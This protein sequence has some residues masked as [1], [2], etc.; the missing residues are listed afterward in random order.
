MSDWPSSSSYLVQSFFVTWGVKRR[1]WCCCK[2][3]RFV[4]NLIA[5]V[6][7]EPCFKG[8]RWIVCTHASHSWGTWKLMS[9]CNGAK[10]SDFVCF[11]QK[12]Q[13]PREFLVCFMQKI[14]EFHAHFISCV[15]P[16]LPPQYRK[17]VVCL[18]VCVLCFG[19]IF[20]DN[21]TAN[22]TVCVCLG[23]SKRLWQQH[24][25]LLFSKE[26]EGREE[27]GHWFFMLKRFH[28]QSVPSQCSWWGPVH[29]ITLYALGLLALLTEG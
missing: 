21:L 28:L 29:W 15:Y 20:P 1:I 17:C 23:C 5:C 4:Q 10:H 16:L 25:G 26:G 7:F 11:V 2:Y 8:Q 14:W 9:C 24:L 3:W 13:Q 18:S 6:N 19:G 22:T 27:G 12:K